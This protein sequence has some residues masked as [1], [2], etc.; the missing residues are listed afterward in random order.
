M[1]D[2]NGGWGELAKHDDELAELYD[3]FGPLPEPGT[4][5]ALDAFVERKRITIPALVRLGARLASYDVIAFAFA[6]GVKFR[7]IVSDRRWSAPGSQWKAMKIVRRGSEPSDTVIVV[8]GETDGARLSDGYDCDIAVLPAGAG[9]FPA[10]YAAQ[11]GGYRLVLVGLDDDAAGNRGAEAITAMVPHAIRFAPPANDW[12]DT[13]ELPELPDAPP[14]EARVLVPA[15][16]L[17][18]L[19]PPE[20]VSWFEGALLPVGGQLI[21]HGW[22]KSYKSFLALDLLSA[23]AQHQ[24]WC[25]FEPAEEPAKVAVMQYEIVW[26]YY[27]RRIRALRAA[28]REPE[29]FDENFLTFTPLRRPAFVAG[30]TTQE[31]AVLRALVDGG[32]QVFLLDPIRRATGAADL[33][34]ERDVRPLL[35]FYGR[36]QDHGIT[37][38]TCHHD[39][40]TYARQGGGDPLGMTG[41]GAFA[42]DADTIVSVSVPKGQTLEDPRRNLHFTLRN[43]PAP[44][45]RGM[46]MGSDGCIVYATEPWG[47]GLA[48]DESGP[49]I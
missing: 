16:E 20:A 29:L 9:Y 22:A 5:P 10:A 39:N 18:A 41:V 25:C 43:A 19:E 6:G 31:D 32:V 4:N 27:Q 23:I 45:P 44:A 48:G 21:L 47:G 42:G 3:G 13:D 46:E 11:L 34:S 7:D 35:N 15:G 26:A 38:V 12:C 37:V 8:E 33:N 36:L 30:N 2:S 14:V 17:L 49:A 1:G 24:D 28:A 40:K